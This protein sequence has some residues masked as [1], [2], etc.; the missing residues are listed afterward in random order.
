[1]LLHFLGCVVRN[2]VRAIVNKFDCNVGYP[3]V[4][5]TFRKID[6]QCVIFG[7]PNQQCWCL[8]NG[9]L[10]LCGIPQQCT[11]IIHHASH[12]LGL[13]PCGSVV[14]NFR[15]RN[16]ILVVCGKDLLHRFDGIVQETKFG[17]KW[18]LEVQNVPTTKTNSNKC[19]FLLL[20]TYRCSQPDLRI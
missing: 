2:P 19:Y 3:F 1:M 5:Q 18:Q 17:C 6:C 7:A 14:L 4:F 15:I 13:R 10:C 12:C 8:D 11:I 16:N 20:C 9:G